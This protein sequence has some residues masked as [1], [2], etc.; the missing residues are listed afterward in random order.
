[1]INKI[2]LIAFSILIIF[3]ILQ[4]KA[5]ESTIK[6][7]YKI[8]TNKSVDFEYQKDDPGSF[9]M[10]MRFR[11]LSNSYFSERDILRLNNYSGR[12]LSLTPEN[13]EQGIGFSYSYS[14]IRGKLNPKFDA[15][16]VYLFPY[17][18]GTKVRVA[19]MGYVGTR[20][21]GKDTP[22]DWSVYRFFTDVEDSITSI[23]KG[24]VVDIKDLHSS[25]EDSNLD[26]TSKINELTIEHA[27]G[28]LAVYKGFR[29]G[30]FSVKIGQTV[31]PGSTLGLNSKQYVNSKF[32]VS[33][34]IIY[35]KSMDFESARNPQ[36]PKSLYGFIKPHF[37]TSLNPA[38]ELEIQKEYTVEETSDIVKKEF[39]KKE[40][41]A[42]SK[43]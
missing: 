39:S 28:T 15:D 9:S 41:K 12:L 8:N 18:K 13:K 30:S 20:Y 1:M 23:R 35:L 21:F 31:Y 6:V 36:N 33:I 22:E 19:N 24:V 16:F 10:I 4:A 42:S 2:K 25:G 7:T 37:Y 27:D 11:D 38:A 26:Y 32:N 17:K 3:A 5:Q 43:Q 14:F 40:L 34:Y 29:K